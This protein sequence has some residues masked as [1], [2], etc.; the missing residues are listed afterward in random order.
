MLHALA[1][2]AAWLAGM[3]AEADGYQPQLNPFSA[4]RRL[5]SLVRLGWEALTRQWLTRPVQTM[6]DTLDSLT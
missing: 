3:A 6:L 1:V 5:Y 2:F 4:P